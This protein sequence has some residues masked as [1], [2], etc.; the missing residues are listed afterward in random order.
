MA[1]TAVESIP[2]M[3][4]GDS[5]I[6]A[7]IT[8]F[9]E[10]GLDKAKVEE[11]EIGKGFASGLN[12]KARKGGYPVRAVLRQGQLFLTRYDWSTWTPPAPRGSKNGE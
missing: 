6:S 8:E 7:L 1:L 5:K 4:K 12:S 2:A 9:V 11:V 3:E 10:S